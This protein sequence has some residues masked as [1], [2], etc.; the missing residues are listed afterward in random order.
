MLCRVAIRPGKGAGAQPPARLSSPPGPRMMVGR[1]GC[2]F[3]KRGRLWHAAPPPRPMPSAA[4]ACQRG[5]GAR[6]G[7]RGSLPGLGWFPLLPCHKRLQTG[8]PAGTGLSPCAPLA[9]PVWHAVKG[10]RAA[11]CPILLPLVPAAL[12]RAAGPPLT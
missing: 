6:A 4:A 1:A 8:V 7:W 3:E 9:V 2:G 5:A 11:R 12:Q 10:F